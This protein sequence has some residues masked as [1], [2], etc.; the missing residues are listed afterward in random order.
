[1]T[2]IKRR[3]ANDLYRIST[4]I[5][6]KFLLN[7]TYPRALS[8]YNKTNKGDRGIFSRTTI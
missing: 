3:M 7:T 6:T 5:L 2:I 4:Q 1:M 8:V